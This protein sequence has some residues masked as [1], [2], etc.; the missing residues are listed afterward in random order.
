MGEMFKN[1]PAITTQ[2]TSPWAPAQGA[3]QDIIGKAQALGADGSTFTPTFSADTTAGLGRLGQLGQQPSAGAAALQ[4]VVNNAVHGSGVGTKT[5]EGIATGDIGGENPYLND[6]IKNGNQ[7]TADAVNAQFN[8]SGRFGSGAHDTALATQIGKNTLGALS[9][10]FNQ[11]TANRAAAAGQLGSM[12][13]QGAGLAPQIDASK[14]Q[15]IGYQIA[16]GQGQ[17]ANANASRLAPFTALQ[18]ESSLINPIAGMGGNSTGTQVQQAN[19]WTSALGVGMM[20]ASMYSDE[21]MKEDIKEVGETHDGQKVYSYRYK[22]DPR[23]QLGLLAQEVEEH[24]PEAVGSAGGMRMVDYK[25]ATKGAERGRVRNPSSVGH[26][27][28]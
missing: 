27:A 24:K 6:V 3:L 21:R 15:Q 11:T 25:A 16:A 7:L 9:G 26:L 12:G 1:K 4:P 14:A 23:T 2:Q 22:G 5:L 17:D 19:P 8:A 20:A 18:A 13:L 28:G 10:Q